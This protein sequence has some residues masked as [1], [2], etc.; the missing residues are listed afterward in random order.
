MFGVPSPIQILPPMNK[1][2]THL[3]AA[4]QI[5]WTDADGLHVSGLTPFPGADVFGSDPMSMSGAQLPLLI[6]IMLPAMSKAREQAIRAKSAKQSA[7]NRPWRSQYASANNGKFPKDM[8]ELLQFDIAPDL[9]VNP[10]GGTAVPPGMTQPQQSQWVR[11]HS[12]YIWNGEGKTSAIGA[13]EPLAWENP[14]AARDGINILYGDG[15]VAF[16]SMFEARDI[17]S[18]AQTKAKGLF[19]KLLLQGANA[20]LWRFSEARGGADILVCPESASAGHSCPAERI[21][22]WFDDERTFRADKL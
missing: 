1:L 7:A 4:G 20:R 22:K 10:G 16:A 3:S 5:T 17:I 13:D 2:A 18:K 6:S 12:D 15:H 14:N 21:Q 11:E 8:G 19:D 9:F